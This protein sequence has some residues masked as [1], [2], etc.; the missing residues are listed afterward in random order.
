MLVHSEL[1]NTDIRIGR[2]RSGES[3][4]VVCVNMLGEGFDLPE[5]KVAAVHDMHRS[6]AILLQFTGRFTRTS[7]NSI[8]NATVVANIADP[9]VSGA[10]ERLYSEDADWNELLSELS[11]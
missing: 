10:L 3:R 11:S 2:L 8:G 7:D 9:D 6:L 4:I 5:L 1:D